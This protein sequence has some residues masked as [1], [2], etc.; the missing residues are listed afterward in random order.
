MMLFF[1]HSGHHQNKYAYN[2][3]KIYKTE[4][5]ISDIHYVGI[6]I[7]ILDMRKSNRDWK[8]NYNSVSF[9]AM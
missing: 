7:Y 8:Y 6:F 5:E 3:E 2:V 1:I 9:V 4:L